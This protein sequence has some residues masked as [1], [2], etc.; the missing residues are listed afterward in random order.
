MAIWQDIQAPTRSQVPIDSGGGLVNQSIAQGMALLKE[1]DR[2]SERDAIVSALA[3]AG[4]NQPTVP[5]E[6]AQATTLGGVASTLTGVTKQN[7]GKAAEPYL[8]TINET[9]AKFGLDP[10]VL[11]NML[12][13]ESRFNPK[14][15]NASS[16]AIGMGQFL[17]GTAKDMGIDPTDANQS[18]YGMGKYMRWLTDQFG[19][20]TRKAVAAYNFGIGNVK[21]GKQ[22]PQETINYQRMVLGG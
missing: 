12:Y 18:I 10:T 11:G 20:D 21:A 5:N 22:L 13:T 8:A 14:A 16:G 3:S 9:A 4:T 15:Y 7:W 1:R 2:A 19:G 6:V 17:P